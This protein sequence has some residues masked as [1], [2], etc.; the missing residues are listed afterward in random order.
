[1]DEVEAVEFIQC[2][3]ALAIAHADAMRE[4]PHSPGHFRVEVRLEQNGWIVQYHFRSRGRGHAG[5]GMY[6]VIHP[7]T[8][9]IISKTFHQ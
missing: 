6:Y 3:H 2:D 5:G 4:N 9:D 1:M 8:G 7:E